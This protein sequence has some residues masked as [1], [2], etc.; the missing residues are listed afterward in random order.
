MYNNKFD[1]SPYTPT[2][3]LPRTEKTLFLCSGQKTAGSLRVPYHNN[4]FI[5][6]EMNVALSEGM[7]LAWDGKC[8][9]SMRKFD[10][11]CV[12]AS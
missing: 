4:I 6:L 1:G 10:I 11:S 2:L 3:K 12:Y 9:S 7:K 5:H 8:S